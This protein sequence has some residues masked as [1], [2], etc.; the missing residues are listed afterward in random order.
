MH[1]S[2]EV[3]IILPAYLVDATECSEIII[4]G[5]TK[6]MTQLFNCFV[7]KHRLTDEAVI[8]RSWGI[9]KKTLLLCQ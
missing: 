7:N 3:K 8:S 5:N 6:F 9:S 4:L 1:I 2:W